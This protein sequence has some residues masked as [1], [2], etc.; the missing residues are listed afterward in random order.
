MEN[1]IKKNLERFLLHFDK[2]VIGN[3][4]DPRSIFVVF[5]TKYLKKEDLAYFIDLYYQLRGKKVIIGENKVQDAEEKFAFLEK[6]RP[7]LKH[8]YYRVM[9]GNLQKNKINKAVKLFAEIWGVDSLNIAREI[10]QRVKNRKLPIFLEINVSG[11][12]SKHGIALKETDNVTYE[13]QKMENLKL[14][15]LMTI[16][17]ET[18]DRNAIREIFRTIKGIAESHK[19]LASMGMSGDWKEAV[20]EGS[21]ILRI[22]STIFD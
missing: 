8:K 16:A 13:I 9:I 22:G 3:G 6:T 18:N 5:A 21:D 19:I 7:D 14:R 17:P 1:K 2:F 15:G 20:L 12:K 4:R 10:N 11:E